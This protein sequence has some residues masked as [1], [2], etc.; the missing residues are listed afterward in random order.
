MRIELV[1]FP[2]CPHVSAAREQLARACGAVG[3]PASWVEHD[4]SRGWVPAHVRGYGSPT[5]LVDGRDVSGGVPSD[6]VSCRV[7][8]D[9][10]RPG[11]PALQQIVEALRAAG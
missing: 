5:I 11:A 1:F 6:A 8:P 9:T 4:V 10:D 2:A 7:Y 3:L